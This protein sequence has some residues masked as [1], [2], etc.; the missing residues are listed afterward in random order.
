MYSKTF[1]AFP[2][3]FTLEIRTKGTYGSSL[4]ITINNDWYSRNQILFTETGEPE[5]QTYTFDYNQEYASFNL[6]LFSDRF[7][8]DGDAQV[9]I[10]DI[11]IID[12]SP[13]EYVWWKNATDTLSHTNTATTTLTLPTGEGTGTG[14]VYVQATNAPSR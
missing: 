13:C 12:N 4:T 14:E 5:Y 2:H 9:W 1:T 6:Q 8:T 10:D 3:G 7:N 11:R